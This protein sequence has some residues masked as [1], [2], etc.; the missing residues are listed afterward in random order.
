MVFGICL[1]FS[2]ITTLIGYIPLVGGFISGVL[3]WAIFIAA[4]IICLPIFIIVLSIAWLRY[5]PKIGLII[6]GIGLAILAVVL[7]VSKTRSGS[8]Q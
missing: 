3:F 8:N 6:L 5:R 7:I 2:P 4:L 1:F